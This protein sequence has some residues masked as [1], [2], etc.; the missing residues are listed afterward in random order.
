MYTTSPRLEEGKY[1]FSIYSILNYHKLM[2]SLLKI[3]KRNFSTILILRSRVEIIFIYCVVV[4]HLTL[5]SV[6][7]RM[8][9][10]NYHI[11]N[12]ERKTR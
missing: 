10:L 12:K 11:G 5:K 6:K 4:H 2:T 7:I 1:L 3:R 8:L 9:H